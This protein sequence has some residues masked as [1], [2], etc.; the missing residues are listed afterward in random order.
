MVPDFPE[1]PMDEFVWEVSPDPRP[2]LDRVPRAADT[3][4]RR[5]L[6]A[7]ACARLVWHRLEARWREAVEVPERYADGLAHQADLVVGLPEKSW[8][9]QMA[10]WFVHNAMLAS[11]SLRAGGFSQL[12]VYVASSLGGDQGE[13]HAPQAH[14]DA[15]ARMAGLVRCVFG[16][17]F[18]TVAFAPT[19]R[20]RN[21][22]SLA[23]AAYDERQL[24]SGDLEPHRL[25]VLADALED[26]GA[27]GDLLAHLRS[28]GSHVRGCWAVDLCLG[29][30]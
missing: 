12:T 14:R 30:S 24:P 5:R 11:A 29:L 10:E 25:A 17:P 1:G 7:C 20:T 21:V 27:P 16:N 3:I 26:A 18:R 23:R 2:M 8:P 28:P 19:S 9:T 4:R 15:H 13:A 6:F 22:V